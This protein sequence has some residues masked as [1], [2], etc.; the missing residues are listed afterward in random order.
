MGK[1]KSSM[2]L[3]TCVGYVMMEADSLDM[4]AQREVS[5]VV[6]GLVDSRGAGGGEEEG[7]EAEERGGTAAD[8]GIAEG[9]TCA[10]GAAESPPRGV[11]ALTRCFISSYTV[12]WIAPWPVCCAATGGVGP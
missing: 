9:C 6:R 2:H 12:N 1:G 7:E 11:R 4:A 10:V 5:R 3:T 8:G